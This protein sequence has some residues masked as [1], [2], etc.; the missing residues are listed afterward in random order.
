M[1]TMTENQTSNDLGEFDEPPLLCEVTPPPGTEKCGKQ[2]VF[3]LQCRC[4]ACKNVSNVVFV[5]KECHDAITAPNKYIGC[6][7][8]KA[9]PAVKMEQT[10]KPL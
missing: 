7:A 8:C 4:P 2:A 1:S 10:W 5:C 9:Y 6:S 3:T